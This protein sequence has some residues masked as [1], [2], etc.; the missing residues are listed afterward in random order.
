MHGYVFI[1][2]K[3]SGINFSNED[4]EEIS[5]DVF[6]TLWKNKDKLFLE[7]EIK[8]YIAG[9]TKNLILNKRRKNKDNTENIEE[10]KNNLYR[11]N[12]T[13]I[14]IEENEKIN[15]LTNKLDSLKEEDRKIF[16]YYYYQSYTIK[17]I[18]KK[19]NISEIKVKS[20]LSRIRKKLRKELERRG[21]SYE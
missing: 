18:S 19:L 17:D 11:E 21:Y 9:I 8:P 2:V 12:D 15:I 13:Y 14:E 7:K 16:I 20:R 6:L 3:N 5:S 4:I 1:I 10:F